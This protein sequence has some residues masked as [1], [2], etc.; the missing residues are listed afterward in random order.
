MKITKTVSLALMC[1]FLFFLFSCSSDDNSSNIEDGVDTEGYDV[2]ADLEFGSGEVMEFKANSV[3]LFEEPFIYDES[4]G[5]YILT[6]SYQIIEDNLIYRL[7]IKALL[8]DEPGT[9]TMYDDVNDSL[10]TLGF[11]IEFV[12]NSVD[13]TGTTYDLYRTQ[14][15]DGEY[16]HLE[17]T[18][19]T[20]DHLKGTFSALIQYMPLDNGGDLKITNGKIDIAIFRPVD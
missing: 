9:Y 13:G 17:I 11:Y 6:S 15:I 12:V 7:S 5:Y 14:Y 3:V 16:G 10:E 2:V 8:K 1:F 4:T 20:D 18:S 19:L